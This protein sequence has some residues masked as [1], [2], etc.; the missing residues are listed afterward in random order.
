[1]LL[2]LVIHFALYVNATNAL[3]D[4]ACMDSCV[5]NYVG[6]DVSSELDFYHRVTFIC[7]DRG[8]ES[9][10]NTANCRLYCVKT[11]IENNEP[12]DTW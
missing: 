9:D 10:G 2:Y 12:I 8:K 5:W 6:D 4:N 1:M 11:A 7:E 3:K